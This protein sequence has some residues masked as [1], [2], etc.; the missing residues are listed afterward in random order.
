MRRGREERSL[1]YVKHD[2]IFALSDHEPLVRDCL[3]RWLASTKPSPGAS[4]KSERP[5]ALSASAEFQ[6]VAVRW[7]D[8][9]LAVM[10]LPPRRWDAVLQKEPPKDPPAELLLEVWKSLRAVGAAVRTRSGLQL[11]L[12]LLLE[13]DRVSSEWRDFAANPAAPTII[14][15]APSDAV[16]VVA[17]RFPPW[18][19]LERWHGVL[20][21]RER[22]ELDKGL[23]GIRGLLL[24]RDVL[25]DVLPKLFAD[26]GVVVQARANVPEEAP[27]W[28][29]WS[30]T[31]IGFVP[32]ESAPPLRE[33]VDNALLFGMN[34]LALDRNTRTESA[35]WSVLTTK[36]GDR[37]RRSLRG[38]LPLQPGYDWLPDRWLLG[39]HE[40][41]LDTLAAAEATRSASPT[42][43][44]LAAARQFPHAQFVA[45]SDLARLRTSPGYQRLA[46]QGEGDQPP[47]PLVLL[48]HIPGIADEAF[49]AGS[50][51]ETG[52]TL[53]LGLTERE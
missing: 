19:I 21:E 25:A 7:P 40:A 51:T 45:W 17:A 42:P 47:L 3:D 39:S 50:W 41:G 11:E 2:Q 13:P 28:T 30:A 38:P 27:W 26:W 12:S 34:L 1:Y 52:I 37:L 49:L 32:R 35:G 43:L 6:D 14:E 15:S 23:S 53:S 5:A 20:S 29:A 22:R 4:A 44:R 18:M 9:A 10:Y 48:R 16:A 8:D 33:A 24:D 36:T 31:A 46:R